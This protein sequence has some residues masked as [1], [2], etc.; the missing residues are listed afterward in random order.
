MKV[1]SSDTRRLKPEVENAILFVTW[2]PSVINVDDLCTTI[3]CLFI[4]SLFTLSTLFR[5]SA[6]TA[7]TTPPSKE[8][9][10]QD[11]TEVQIRGFDVLTQ[12][13]LHGCICRP[14]HL[15][16]GKQY[17]CVRGERLVRLLHG[18]RTAHTCTE[19]GVSASPYLATKFSVSTIWICKVTP[20]HSLASLRAL[21]LLPGSCA[22]V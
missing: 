13:D 6:C 16:P 21:A 14:R 20:T 18:S 11:S 19:L 7:P 15:F 12:E 8:E 9:G 10:R 17:K 2:H 22:T 4:S 5:N 1:A 3:A